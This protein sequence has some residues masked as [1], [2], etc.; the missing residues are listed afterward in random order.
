L[1]AAHGRIS[2]TSETWWT[3][4]TIDSTSGHERLPSLNDMSSTRRRSD[5][6][7]AGAPC[8][9]IGIVGRMLFSRDGDESSY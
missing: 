2:P 8:H 3:S 1:R 4:G 7:C 6:V 5:S 9:R